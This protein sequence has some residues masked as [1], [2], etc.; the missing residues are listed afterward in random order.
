MKTPNPIKLFW[1]RIKL[2]WNT[3]K[4]SEFGRGLCYPLGLFLAHEG[5]LHSMIDDYKEIAKSA[6]ERGHE[7]YFNEQRAVEMWFNGAADHFFEFMPEFAPRHLYR[8]CYE[9]QK[10][11]L[12]WRLPMNKAENPTKE[13]AEWALQEAKIL[14][15]EIDQAWVIPAVKGDYE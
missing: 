7:D 6:K 8:R 3:P 10:Q 9:L 2:R 11:C 12:H 13:D 4:D 5:K 15:K 1:L 14:L